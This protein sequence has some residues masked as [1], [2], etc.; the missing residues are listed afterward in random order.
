MTDDDTRRAESRKRLEG[1]GW[2]FAE[3]LGSGDIWTAWVG[4]SGI[5]TITFT[6]TK[7][8]DDA[9]D[10]AIRFASMATMKR[11]AGRR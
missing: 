10:K 2:V 1:E 6:S 11:K 7:S 8:A 3:P 9:L 5:A 4:G